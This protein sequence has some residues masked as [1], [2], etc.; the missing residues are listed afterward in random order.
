MTEPNLQ[1]PRELRR[2]GKLEDEAYAQSSALQLI[3]LICDCLEV[4]DLGNASV[5]DMGC[6]YRLAQTMLRNNVP[7]GHYSGLDVYHELIAYLQEN[8]NDERFEFH[9]LNLHNE[10]YNPGGEL[11]SAD[12][13]LPVPEAS[14]DIICLF[15]VFTHLAPHDYS[16]MLKML[17]RYVKPGGGLLFSLFVYETTAGGLGFIDKISTGLNISATDI[18]NWS[19]P[20]AFKDW[21][22]QQPLK[23][24]IYSRE[25][26]LELVEGTGWKVES[27]NDPRTYIQHHMLCTPE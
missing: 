26:A 21:D 20:P 4:P 23:W 2:G 9:P 5:L 19:G 14:F 16:A 13:Q 11:L 6:G 12:F 24:A 1:V 25:H 3:D 7:I 10:M 22:P 15:S 8:V 17:R 27:L 18:E